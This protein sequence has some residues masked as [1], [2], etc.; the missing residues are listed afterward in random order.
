MLLKTFNQVPNSAHYCKNFLLAKPLVTNIMVSDCQIAFAER[1]GASWSAL[2]RTNNV[3][4]WYS[5]FIQLEVAQH[6]TT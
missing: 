4:H 2:A 3:G 1:V 5:K 6:F